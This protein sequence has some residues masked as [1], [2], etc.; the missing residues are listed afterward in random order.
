MQVTTPGE[1]DGLSCSNN[2]CNHTAEYR[3]NGYTYFTS[4]CAD[5]SYA[6]GR[7][8]GNRECTICPDDDSCPIPV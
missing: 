1:D 5:G 4:V 2:G 7:V 3:D 6:A 8:A